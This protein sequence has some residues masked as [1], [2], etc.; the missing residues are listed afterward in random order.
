MEKRLG[1]AQGFFDQMDGMLDESSEAYRVSQVFEAQVAAIQSSLQAFAF[2]NKV[3]GPV[4]GGIMAAAAYAVAQLKVRQMEANSKAEL[5]MMIPEFARGAVLYG[6]RYSQGGIPGVVRS[7]G[8]PSEME[9]GEIILTRR[10]GLDPLGRAMASELN[11]KYGGIRF[12]TGGPVNPLGSSMPAT[13]AGGS[14][15]DLAELTRAMMTLNANF[16]DY[17]AKVG[18]WAS[19]LKVF[20]NEND[21]REGFKLLNK[22][23]QRAN[24]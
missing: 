7:T 24:W 1:V 6:R 5:G 15:A 16:T 18:S 19:A 13:S 11:A 2:G 23:E 21:T 20:N 4:V 14:S 22:L 3:G 10:V 17:A 12:D 9:G 8:E